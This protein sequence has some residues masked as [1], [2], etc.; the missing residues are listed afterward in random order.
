MKFQIHIVDDEHTVA[1]SLKRI[2]TTSERE[3]EVS[4]SGYEALKKTET[5]SFDLFILDY[6]LGDMDGIQLLEHLKNTSADAIYIFITAFGNVETAVR[7]MKAGAFDFIQKDQNPEVI[8]FTVQRALDTIRLRKEVELLKNSI[9]QERG[10]RKMVAES[11][12]MKEILQI[13][14]KY[15]QT[16]CTILI[17]G[18]TGTGKNV[19]AEFIH[20]QSNRF[21]NP[22]LAINCCTIPANLMESELFGYEKGAFTGAHTNGKVGLIE[23][24]NEG[25]LFLDEIG[26]LTP[27][28]Q[29]KLLYIIERQEFLRIGSVEPQKVNTRIIAATN[30]DLEK[31]IEEKNFRSDLYYRLNVASIKLPPLRERK[32]DI[33]PLSKLFIE[34]FN[35]R[36][37]KNVKQIADDAADYL[38]NAP[39]K[40]NIRELKNLLERVMILTEE[41]TLSF[42]ELQ[43]AFTPFSN[44]H[45]PEKNAFFSLHLNPSKGTNLL[46]ESQKQLVIQALKKCNC[47]R[48]SAA[49][50]LGIP[51]TTLNF[52]LKK[53][54]LQSEE[55]ALKNS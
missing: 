8:R 20:Y 11:P 35:K 31:M 37:N 47:N 14:E 17:T 18:E 28:L 50:M 42:R 1:Q 16:D 3:I 41:E 34:E 45:S 43:K 5:K 25:T 26:E 27:D 55:P 10:P 15:A 29:A 33:L 39:W 53:F 30:V 48:S 32:E 6:R 46:Q 19:L 12:V 22:F 44:D 40:G 23:R 7:A 2:L 38:I 21:N 51:R 52:Y 49:R 54:D 24:A 9:F 36:F 13:A 4:N